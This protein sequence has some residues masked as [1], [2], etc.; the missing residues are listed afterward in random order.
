MPSISRSHVVSTVPEPTTVPPPTQMFSMETPVLTAVLAR[1]ALPTVTARVC[2]PDVPLIRLSVQPLKP[3]VVMQSPVPESKLVL[4]V[5][6]TSAAESQTRGPDTTVSTLGG[7]RAEDTRVLYSTQ[8]L[9]RSRTQQVE[10]SKTSSHVAV[11]QTQVPAAAH[12]TQVVITQNQVRPSPAQAS[13]PAQIIQTTVPQVQAATVAQPNSISRVEARAP[14]Q[15]GQVG[16]SKFETKSTVVASSSSSSS[17]VPAT[18]VVAQKGGTSQTAA[19]VTR[20][21]QDERRG[22]TA[23]VPDRQ[24][25]VSSSVTGHRDQ[26]EQRRGTATAQVPDRQIT[27]TSGPGEQKRRGGPAAVAD[28]VDRALRALDSI[29]AETRSLSTSL[30]RDATA[31]TTTTTTSPLRQQ[32]SQTS[33]AVV[34]GSPRDAAVPAAAPAAADQTP[35]QLRSPRAADTAPLQSAKSLDSSGVIKK[36]LVHLESM[37]RPG[38]SDPHLKKS[39]HLR[40]PRPLRKAQTLDL[41]HVGLGVDPELMQLLSTRKEK[42]ASDEEDAAARPRDDS[43]T[44]RYTVKISICPRTVSYTHLTLPTILRV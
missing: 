10:A 25:T 42:S 38:A 8:E 30:G 22:G 18:S 1:P 7:S 9:P 15:A 31:S 26:A 23:A 13:K 36:H 16:V 28:E 2:Q 11:P 27:V 33:T 29:A 19:D 5:P 4:V 41:T 17:V 24:L 20:S 34:V 43:V 14:G 35:R 37:F 3:A 44:A 12:R 32:P 39:V 21:T 40:K 6:Q